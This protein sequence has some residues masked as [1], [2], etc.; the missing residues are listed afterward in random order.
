MDKPITT[1]YVVRHGESESNANYKHL[2]DKDHKKWGELQSPLTQK[3]RQQAKQIAAKLSD[4]EFDSIFSSDLLRARQTAEIIAK[5]N[6]LKVN[7]VSTIRERNYG[8]TFYRL[9]AQEKN[10]VKKAVM[11]LNDEEKLLYKF[12]NDGESAQEGVKRFETFLNEIAPLYKGKKIVVVNHGNVMRM[13][14][15]HIGWARFNELPGGSIKNTGYYVLELN[16]NIYRVKE[17]AG[18]TKQQ[19]TEYY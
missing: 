8:E 7:T 13:F 17:T 10:E 15:I 9:S 2:T 14:L 5:K 12:S 3:G 6:N 18:I 4:I 1:I 16:S 19:T 11:L